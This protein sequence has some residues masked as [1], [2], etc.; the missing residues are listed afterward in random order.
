MFIIGSGTGLSHS[1]SF[2]SKLLSSLK[3]E[4]ITKSCQMVYQTRKFSICIHNDLKGDYDCRKPG[5]FN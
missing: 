4:I 5:I 2:S 1:S 3:S